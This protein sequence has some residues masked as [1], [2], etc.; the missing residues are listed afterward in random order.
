MAASIDKL[1]VKPDAHPSTAHG[2]S[3]GCTI[4]RGQDDKARLHLRQAQ[5]DHH[6]HNH[7]IFKI[8][9]VHHPN[10]LV[11]SVKTKAAMRAA[12]ELFYSAFIVLAVLLFLSFRPAQLLPDSCPW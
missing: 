5:G 6:I 8:V 1:A 7:S 12:F 10:G 3:A 4:Q 9:Q 11:C 2:G